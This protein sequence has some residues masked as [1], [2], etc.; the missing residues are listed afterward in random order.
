MSEARIAAEET[1]GIPAGVAMR[2]MPLPKQGSFVWRYA[3]PDPAPQCTICGTMK[4]FDPSTLR[5]TCGRRI[6]RQNAGI[7]VLV[8]LGL[9]A[10]GY[11]AILYPWV[12]L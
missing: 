2:L 10:I 5:Q 9:S 4:V 1:R 12:G 11:A 3:P 6:R 8:I 7:C